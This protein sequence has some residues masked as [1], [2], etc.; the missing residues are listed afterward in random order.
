[1]HLSLRIVFRK[2]S[3][4]AQMTILT[5]YYYCILAM[6]FL[7]MFLVSEFL[8]YVSYQNPLAIRAEGETEITRAGT[9]S[10]RVRG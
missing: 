9:M 4:H 1:M 3:A 7:N 10:I 6:E 2:W 8:L 5:I